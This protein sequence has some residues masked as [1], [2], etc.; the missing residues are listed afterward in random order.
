MAGDSQ[1]SLVPWLV[2]WLKVNPQL[3]A[4]VQHRHVPCALMPLCRVS[5][6]RHHGHDD[7]TSVHACMVQA[8]LLEVRD[9][10]GQLGCTANESAVQETQPRFWSHSSYICVHG[11]RLI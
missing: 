7:I 2:A 10:R 4:A 1:F 6:P 11:L 3:G 5:L 8:V 9:V